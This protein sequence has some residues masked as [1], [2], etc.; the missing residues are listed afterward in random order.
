MDKPVINIKYISDCLSISSKHLEDVVTQASINKTRRS[1]I[2]AHTSADSNVQEML[3]AF[4][5]DSYVRPHRHNNK[6]ESFHV[7][8]G[9]LDI[10]F[11]DENGNIENRIELG[12]YDSGK[13]FFLR[14]L[15]QGW[16]TAYI[17]SDYVLIH[18]TTNGPFNPIE[19]EFAPWSPIPENIKAVNKFLLELRVRT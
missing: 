8:H 9:E 4:C 18:E 13:P 3:I 11:F 5:K 12:D 7:I 14:S 6:I 16:H 19:S 17:K 2:N 1:R 15:K 10:I